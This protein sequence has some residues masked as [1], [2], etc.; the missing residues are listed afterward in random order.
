MANKNTSKREDFL[1]TLSSMTPEEVTE[2]I[3]ENSKI[4]TLSNVVVRINTSKK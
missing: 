2:L 3:L 1:K 4:K